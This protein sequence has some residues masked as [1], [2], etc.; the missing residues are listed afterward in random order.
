MIE[1]EDHVSNSFHALLAAG[2]TS[3]LTCVAIVDTT[4]ATSPTE[5]DSGAVESTATVSG[6]DESD[7]LTLRIGTDDEP[8]RPAADQ[9]EEFARSVAEGSEGAIVVEPVWHAAGLLRTGTRRLLGW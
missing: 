9:I 1:R 8:G 6:A 5:P 7:V 3:L 2:L 4:A